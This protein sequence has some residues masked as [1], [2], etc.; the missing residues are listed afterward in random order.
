MFDYLLRIFS[1]IGRFLGVEEGTAAPA[2][3]EKTLDRVFK[4][5]SPR[6][7]AKAKASAWEEDL[8]GKDLSMEESPEV[9]YSVGS[10]A[11]CRSGLQKIARS[12][13]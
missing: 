8:E 9:L 5:G 1:R 10:P 2:M 11:F 4:Y 7:E 3:M 13:G 6:Q 12:G